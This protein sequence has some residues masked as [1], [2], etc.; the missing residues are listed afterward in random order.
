VYHSNAIRT[1]SA[2]YPSGPAMFIQQETDQ[3]STPHSL[4]LIWSFANK[5]SINDVPYTY[6]RLEGLPQSVASMAKHTAE[7]V[8]L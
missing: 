1:T 5:S 3:P 6:V 7:E 8:S 4:L 2:Y